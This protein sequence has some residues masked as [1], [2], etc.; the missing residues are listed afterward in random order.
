MAMASSPTATGC[1]PFRGVRRRVAPASIARHGPIVPM[2]F[3][4]MPARSVRDRAVHA[5]SLVD[6]TIHQLDNP[7]RDI[8]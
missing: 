6:R 8:G 5:E 4:T 7:R 1:A 2:T 3:G